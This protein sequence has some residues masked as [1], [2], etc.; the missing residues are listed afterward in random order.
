MIN[1]YYVFVKPGMSFNSSIVIRATSPQK[2]MEI[3]KSEFGNSGSRSN[4][5]LFVCDSLKF[6]DFTLLSIIK[7]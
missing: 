1:Q 3:Y 4:L 7:G 5:A 6:Y 2:A